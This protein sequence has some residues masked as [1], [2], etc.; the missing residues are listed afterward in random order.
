MTPPQAIVHESLKFA[1]L[2]WS[3]GT[4]RLSGTAPCD[5][6]LKTTPLPVP[7]DHE[8]GAKIQEFKLKGLGG[9]YHVVIFGCGTKAVVPPTYHHQAFG[10]FCTSLIARY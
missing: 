4:R 6:I 3:R 2:P 9:S 1:P 7:R 10:L 5:I 8:R